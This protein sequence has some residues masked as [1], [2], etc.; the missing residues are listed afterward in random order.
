MLPSVVV[1]SVLCWCLPGL[2]L[3]QRA[4]NQLDAYPQGPAAIPLLHEIWAF[5]EATIFPRSLAQRFDAQALLKFEGLL[6]SPNAVALA[7][8]LNP[9][10]ESLGVSH[11][12]LY[13]VRHQTYYL[14][15]SLFSTRDLDAP[16]LHTIGVQFDEL[17]PAIVQAVMEQSPAAIAGLQRG[18]RIVAVNGASFQSLLQWQQTLPTRFTVRG[19]Q[20]DR[21]VALTPVRQSLHRALAEAT[22]RSREIYEC[23]SRRIAYF[24]LWSGTHPIFLEALNHAVA[25]TRQHG[26]NGFVLDLRDGYG[27]AWWDYLDPFFPSRDD[28]F[29]FIADDARGAGEPMRAEPRTNA[30]FWDGPL[31]VIINRGTRSGKEAL[32]F[33]FKKTGRATLFGERTSIPVAELPGT[34]APLAAALDHLACGAVV[35]AD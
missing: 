23:G 28:Y 22:A 4:E 16:Q 21:D 13:D 29:Q 33:Q 20:G 25:D 27:G 32:A 14:Q 6:R 10:L 34:D 3:A 31:A 24:H 15:R 19:A 30:A 11:T 8:A 9:F 18:E 26:V 12:R 2:G 7:D 1:A 5:S 17:D 35:S